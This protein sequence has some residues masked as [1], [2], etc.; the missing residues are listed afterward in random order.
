MRNL[1]VIGIQCEKDLVEIGIPIGRITEY[2]VNTRAKTRL[3]QCVSRRS[4]GYRIEVSEVLLRDDV[5]LDELKNTIYHEQIH[6]CYGCM[7]HGERWKRFA[8]KVSVSFGID[9][10]RTA[11]NGDKSVQILRAE[12]DK[13][14]PK[15]KYECQSCGRIHTNMR[16]SGFTRQP[17]RYR[18][19]KCGT[20]GNWKRIS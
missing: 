17:E 19:G 11:S 20:L 16:E 7:N 9:I 6:T 8:R 18:C 15:Y 2:T 4:G 12:L 5:P 1:A 14:E 13:R 3:G 10:S